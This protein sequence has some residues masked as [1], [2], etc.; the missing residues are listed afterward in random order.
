[1]TLL[2]SQFNVDDS[3]SVCLRD[4]PSGDDRPAQ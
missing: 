2:L 1:M 3:N 4:A